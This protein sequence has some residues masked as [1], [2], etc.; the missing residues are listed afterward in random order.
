M[1]ASLDQQ[2]AHRPAPSTGSRQDGQSWGKA[3]RVNRSTIPRTARVSSAKR[4]AG[5]ALCSIFP[6]IATTLG[7]RADSS[8]T[9]VFVRSICS[10]SSRRAN[11]K[12]ICRRHHPR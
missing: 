1:K 9:D 8:R 2:L 10:E 6:C 5:A 4:L 7:S 11:A 3:T 12:Q